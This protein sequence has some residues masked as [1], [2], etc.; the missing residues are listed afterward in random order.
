MN[1]MPGRQ[2]GGAEGVLKDGSGL[3]Q[4]AQKLLVDLYAVVCCRGNLM[5]AQIELK[6]QL[7][8]QLK[9]ER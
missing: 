2:S 1:R 9:L 5:L 6:A 8:S 3:V 4:E 7:R